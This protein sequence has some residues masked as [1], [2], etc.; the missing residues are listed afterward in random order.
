MK[1]ICTEYTTW[2]FISVLPTARANT[3]CHE[4]LL[5]QRTF[6]KQAWSASL[7]MNA[8]PITASLLAAISRVWICNVS[9]LSVYDVIFVSKMQS[10]IE[11]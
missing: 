8:R 5:K 10:V 1:G 11:C 6:K 2:E 3:G 4:S 9:V 7:Q